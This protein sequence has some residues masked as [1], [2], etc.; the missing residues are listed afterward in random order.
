MI[1]GEK[2]VL[3]T[4]RETDL[5]TL[6]NLMSD[7]RNRGEYYPL[8]LN[9]EPPMQ[10]DFHETGF[11]SEEKGGRLLICDR[12]NKIV[13]LMFVDKEPSYFNG[14]E[15]GYILYDEASRNK[16][17]VTEAV[18]LATRYLFST[19]PINRIQI[20]VLSANEASKKIALKC[21]FKFE[22]IARGAFFHDGRN[23]DVEVY[24]IL[25]EESNQSKDESAL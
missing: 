14:L 3:R 6:F 2:V 13:G 20:L 7:L 16:G 21:G 10:K 22:G 17:Y 8:Y 19:R 24:S 4:I 18:L 23:Q 9:S 1:R 15:L 11:W 5:E 12:E 25:R